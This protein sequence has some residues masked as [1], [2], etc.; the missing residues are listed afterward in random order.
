MGSQIAHLGRGLG[1]RLDVQ[2]VLAHFIARVRDFPYFRSIQLG[3]AAHP[4][5]VQWVMGF[6]FTGIRVVGW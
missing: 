4:A 1:E 5:S 2:V 3:I 6:I